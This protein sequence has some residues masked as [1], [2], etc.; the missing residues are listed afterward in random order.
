MARR[1]RNTASMSIDELAAMPGMVDVTMYDVSSSLWRPGKKRRVFP[2]PA[3][4]EQW[5][6][7]RQAQGFLTEE[8]LKEEQGRMQMI[9]RAAANGPKEYDPASIANKKSG[10]GQKPSRRPT[11]DYKMPASVANNGNFTGVVRM[12]RDYDRGY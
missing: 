12:G 2:S 9:I 3:I 10:Y 8:D 4:A 7:Q 1:K 6:A 5:V 11:R